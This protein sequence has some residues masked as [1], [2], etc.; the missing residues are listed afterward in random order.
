M[1][2][3]TVRGRWTWRLALANAVIGAAV[4]VVLAASPAPVTFPSSHWEALLL[5]A[6]ALILIVA[7]GLIGGVGAATA[8]QRGRAAEADSPELTRL[9][10]YEHFHVLDGEGVI[11]TVAEVLGDRDGRPAA[12][13]VEDGWFAARRFVVPLD[14]VVYVDHDGRQLRLR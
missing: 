11:G 5:L 12:L 2:R 6:G 7:N 1:A 10:E 3:L 9:R 14:A 4:F 13:V 8:L